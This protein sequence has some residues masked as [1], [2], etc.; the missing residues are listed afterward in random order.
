MS[1]TIKNPQKYH[2]NG[3]FILFKCCD[4]IYDFFTN[5]QDNTKLMKIPNDQTYTTQYLKNN[6]NFQS[7]LL[8][9]NIFVTNNHTVNISINLIRKKM[10]KVFHATSTTSTMEKVQ[11]LSTVLCLNN[12][13]HNNKSTFRPRLWTQ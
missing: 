11:V 6:P 7:N 5:I 8:D 9:N 13:L 4:Y 10:I 2:I 12:L 3:G 1:E